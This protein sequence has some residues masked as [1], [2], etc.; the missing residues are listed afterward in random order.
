MT[1]STERL[2][3]EELKAFPGCNNYSDE[4]CIEIIESLFEISILLFE[5]ADWEKAN[6]FTNTKS[7]VPFNQD[8]DLNLAA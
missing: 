1:T 3:I 7:I 6:D 5:M 2:T 4:E 8:N